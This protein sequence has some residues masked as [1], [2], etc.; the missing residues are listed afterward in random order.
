MR[1]GGQCWREILIKPE[2]EQHKDNL[3]ANER[4]RE[5]NNSGEG[6]KDS[7]MDSSGCAAPSYLSANQ[8]LW[9][10]LSSGGYQAAMQNR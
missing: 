7:S 4:E 6:W 1:K 8:Q 5:L 10:T 3:K 9:L 2:K